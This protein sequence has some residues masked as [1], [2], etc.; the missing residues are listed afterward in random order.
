MKKLLRV[1]PLLFLLAGG[2]CAA[3]ALQTIRQIDFRNF[4]FPWDGSSP[5]TAL[6]FPRSGIGCMVLLNQ[7]S[8][9]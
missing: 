6:M 3:N 4:T 8:S 9:L 5:M 7:S 2:L 1:G